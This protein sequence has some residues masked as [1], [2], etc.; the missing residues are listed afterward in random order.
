MSIYPAGREART[1]PVQRVVIPCD[2]GFV[3]GGA[4]IVGSAVTVSS[5]LESPSDF[6]GVSMNELDEGVRLFFD[7]ASFS[8]QLSGKRILRVG[9][10]YTFTG[11]FVMWDTLPVLPRPAQ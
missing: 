11:S 9:L 6:N 8:A 4:Q 7:T 2:S 3:S 10:L 5:A 1:G